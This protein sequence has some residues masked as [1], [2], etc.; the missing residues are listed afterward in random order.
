[1]RALRWLSIGSAAALLGAAGAGAAGSL[2]F[3]RQTIQVPTT[4]GAWQGWLTT[5]LA[6]VDHDG[7]VDV[8]VV[9][10][11]QN[12]LW[13]YRQRASGFPASPDQTIALPAQT[14]WISVADVD[15]Q[16]GPA[17]LFSTA[18][19]L[20]YLRQNHA[21]FESQ[22]QPLI[23]ANQVFTNGDSPRLFR[24]NTQT[25]ETSPGLPVISASQV[26]LYQRVSAG[27]WQPGPP[28]PLQARETQW[29][30]DR[31]EWRIG[32]TPSR[33]LEIHQSFQP[34]RPAGDLEQKAEEKA[35]K[36]S[37]AGKESGETLWE[38]FERVDIN[39]DGREDLVF[40]RVMGDV[41][42]K[43]DILVFLRRAN[44]RLP[45]R[46]TQVL[47]CR[48]CPV[49]VGPKAQAGPRRQR[50]SPLC[51]LAGDGKYQLVLVAL[52]ATIYS[53]SA[54]VDMLLSGNLEWSLTIRNFNHG[55]FSLTPDAAVSFTAMTPMELAMPELFRIEGDFN[56]DGRPDLL[57]R[58]S[59][60]QWDLLLSSAQGWF[61]PKPAFSF[62][63]PLDGHFDIL[64]LNG[65][66]LS[67]LVVEAWDEPKLFVFLSH[68]VK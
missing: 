68:K 23:Q 2:E 24:S 29:H 16:P 12:K 35:V 22:P 39:G 28:L 54:I 31:D 56:G 10:P 58:R 46:P 33:S 38:G 9:G 51:D 14:A 49:Q 6:D 1:M 63:I 26:V 11:M 3:Q 15:A 53:Y 20:S 61:T 21:V 60:T 4:A 32:S 30:M 34:A 41:E 36:K 17:L 19:G 43:T 7:L 65:D 27:E 18:T 47:H 52:K 67:D 37:L 55:L 57:V 25:N 42:P 48:G 13:L 62:E 8:L 50:M 45:D 66:G 5:G 40:W 64:D 44:N 59:P